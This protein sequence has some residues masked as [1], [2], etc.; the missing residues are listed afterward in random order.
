MAALFFTNGALFA[1]LFPR[2]PAI[3]E[4]LGLSNAEFGFAVATYPP[5]APSGPGLPPGCGKGRA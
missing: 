4:V 1:N 3:K 5:W 2:F